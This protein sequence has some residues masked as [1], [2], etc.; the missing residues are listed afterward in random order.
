MVLIMLVLTKLKEVINKPALKML[1]RCGDASMSSD[2]MMSVA[3]KA[4][5]GIATVT[6]SNSTDLI[7]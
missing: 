7:T 5:V 2:E 6:H 1:A 3:T 4:L